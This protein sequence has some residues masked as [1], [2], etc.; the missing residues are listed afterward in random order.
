[1][2]TVKICPSYGI[3]DFLKAKTSCDQVGV[4]G[5]A[6]G[7]GGGSQGEHGSFTSTSEPNKVQQVHFQTSGILL[8][9]GIQKLCGPEISQFLWHLLESLDNLQ[10]LFIF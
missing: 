4:K 5:V 3:F 9:T 7:G 1:M 8:F 10:Q 6:T 2:F